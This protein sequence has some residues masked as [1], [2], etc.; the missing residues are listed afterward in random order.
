MTSASPSHLFSG[1]PAITARHPICVLL[2]AG[3]HSTRELPTPAA[4][5]KTRLKSASHSVPVTVGL[6]QASEA[7]RCRREEA[8]AQYPAMGTQWPLASPGDF[9]S[10][11]GCWGKAG[12]RAGAGPDKLPHA[13]PRLPHRACVRPSARCHGP[14]ALGHPQKQRAGRC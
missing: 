12:R 14:A 9:V 2:W 13:R 5:P 3:S 11:P 7:S 1:H 6:H 4:S 8:G 10:P